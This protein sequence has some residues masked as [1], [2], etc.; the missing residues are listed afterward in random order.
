MVDWQSPETIPVVPKYGIEVFWL[1]VEATIKGEKQIVVFDALYINKP[2]EYENSDDEEPLDSD[3]H[4]DLDG[5][6][7]QA[8]GWHRALEHEEFSNYYE[9][10]N[11]NDDYV[12]L[13][14]GEYLKPDFKR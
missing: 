4:V 7:I 3:Y 8:I 14:W 6:P 2:L 5:H 10:I 12:L 11:F 13:G 9:Q 1:A